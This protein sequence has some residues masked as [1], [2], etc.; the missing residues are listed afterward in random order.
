MSRPRGSVILLAVLL[1]VVL[2]LAVSF[3]RAQIVQGNSV[4][5]VNALQIAGVAAGVDVVAA[6]IPAGEVYLPVTADDWREV[7]F[8]LATTHG[9]TVCE[10]G[11]NTLLVTGSDGAAALC[12][13]E[14]E[15]DALEEEEA[16][17]M[18]EAVIDETPESR[19]EYYDIR[20]RVI[21]I[22]EQAGVSAGFDW[23][24]TV[25]DTVAAL[26][27]GDAATAARRFATGEITSAIR[28]LESEGIGRRLDDISVRARTGLPALF[29]SGGDVSV[30]LVGAGNE[31]IS[32]TYTYGL[33]LNVTPGERD[34]NGLVLE[35]N[36]DS[37]APVNVSNPEL[38]TLTRRTVDTE[39]TIG[40][41]QAV[42][43]GS[44]Y[45][46]AEDIAG[47]GLPGLSSIPVAGYAFGTAGVNR[48]A[49]SAV[50]TLEVTCVS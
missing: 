7:L 26:V 27:V 39:V 36:L 29:R 6:S 10:L 28:F 12:A 25:F 16:P 33:A 41:G 2:S 18:P 5:L 24:S 44:I 3:G 47:Q 46:L 15:P 21:E 49:S 42:V 30:N 13:P 35:V 32:R 20:L 34:D 17:A 31:N 50:L 43:L 37:S 23:G 40:C 38:L 45:R 22:S 48:S 1:G 8:V 4:P 11:A 19:T 9:L 14:P